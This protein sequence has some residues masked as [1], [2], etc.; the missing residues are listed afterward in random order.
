M[1]WGTQA[2]KGGYRV[3]GSKW[4]RGQSNKTKWMRKGT[5]FSSQ[6]GVGAEYVE[7]WEMNIKLSCYKCGLRGHIA[8]NCTSM[9]STTVD[10]IKDDRGI[11]FEIK[12]RNAREAAGN[13]ES[14]EIAEKSD[15]ELIALLKS[16][17]HHDSFRGL[18]LPT[19]QMIL[20]GES[21]LSIMATGKSQ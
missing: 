18:Q 17:F 11:S 9:G 12:E 7:G 3:R 4:R 14:Y 5:Q 20:R 21:C 16:Q 10:T 15:L 8:R 2:G 19:I 1:K 6:A 13:T